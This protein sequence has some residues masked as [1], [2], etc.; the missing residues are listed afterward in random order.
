M[1]G[2]LLGFAAFLLRYDRL[3]RDYAVKKTHTEADIHSHL[4]PH[5][6]NGPL[7]L[8]FVDVR[9]C[10]RALVVLVFSSHLISFSLAFCFVID[11]ISTCIFGVVGIWLLLPQKG[12]SPAP[13]SMRGCAAERPTMKSVTPK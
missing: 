6:E 7:R 10:L 3:S 4:Y 12:N 8:L 5:I 11:I 2:L 9:W 13:L 1:L